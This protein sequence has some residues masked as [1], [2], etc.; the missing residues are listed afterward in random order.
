M[1]ILPISFAFLL[2][3]LHHAAGDRID[4]EFEQITLGTVIKLTNSLHPYHLHS[5]EIPY[6]SG[7]Q[8]QVSF[9]T[10]VAQS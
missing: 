3:L 1:N 7:S 10:A 2:V 6:S 8:Q 5:H 4:P 9:V